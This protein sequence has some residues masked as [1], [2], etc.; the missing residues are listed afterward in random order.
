MHVFVTGATGFIPSHLIS[1]LVKEGHQVSGLIRHS[2]NRPSV[3]NDLEGGG[4]KIYRGDLLDYY[5]LVNI[6]REARPDVVCHLGAITPVAYSFGHPIEVNEVNFLGTMRLVE[7]IKATNDHLQKFI[8]SS[9]MEVYG[10]QNIQV[11]FIEILEPHPIA[12][13]AVS[14]YAAEKYLELQSRVYDFP[15][16]SFRQT[17]TYGRRHNDYFVVEAIITKILRAKRGFVDL[18]RKE[19]TR[20]LIYVDDLVDLWVK[21]INMKK[22]DFGQQAKGRVFNTGPENGLTIGELYEKI[23]TKLNWQGRANWN[24]VELRPG[25]VF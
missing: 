21:A 4:V 15:A 9:S 18:G 19:P 2:S 22:A 6:M 23:A 13:Y 11:P 3:L 1:R 24:A 12:P 25:E 17:N 7:A 5:G 20:N 14:K 10:N 16:M 8:F